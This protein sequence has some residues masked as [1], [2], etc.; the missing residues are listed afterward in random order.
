MQSKITKLTVAAAIILVGMVIVNQFGGS[1][2]GT[3]VA[4]ADVRT[5]FLAQSWVHLRY[6]NG[7]ESWYNLETGD[8]GHKQ[9]Y[10]YGESFVYINHTDNLRQ[11]YTPEHRKHIN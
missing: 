7:T 10:S 1:I 5:A 9:L 2:D 4:F 3:S 8:H 6:D 11:R